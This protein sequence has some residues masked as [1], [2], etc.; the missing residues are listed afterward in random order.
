M[1]TRH[2]NL[3][4]SALLALLLT[5]CGGTPPAVNGNG[6]EPNGEEPNGEE[7]DTTPPTLVSVS[8]EDGATGVRS[9][10][11]VVIVFSEPMDQ[12]SVEGT[13][14]TSDLGEVT[15]SWNEAG[16]TLTITPDEPLV[17]AQGVGTNPGAVE[18]ETYSVTMG[19]AARDLAGNGFGTGFRIDFSTL[20]EISHSFGI[21]EELS[22]S[23]TPTFVV[24]QAYL[25]VGDFYNDIGVR[26][27]ITFD[28]SLLPFSTVEIA[29]A[30]LSTLQ[31]PEYEI[32]SPYDLGDAVL[33]D[34]VTFDSL[35]TAYGS[36]E[37]AHAHLGVFCEAEQVDI[38]KDVTAAVED[39]RIHR[40][41]RG[42]RSQF[43]L[44]FAEE[45]NEDGEDDYGLIEF[46][47]AEL[48]VTYL[49][50]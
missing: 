31:Y 41:A 18:A 32:G 5:A 21:V 37:T 35:D 36:D 23:V 2:S 27:A 16:D 28:I 29:S 6:D 14:D 45:T 13:L 43:L 38:D 49:A 46:F 20:K 48:Q 33:I 34:H 17:Y 9:D 7:V 15:F 8:P 44:R 25:L 42:A 50:P 1:K 24:P 19:S 40:D 39:D 12:A 22:D 10:A 11:S 3:L 30:V 47:D 26:G 4:L